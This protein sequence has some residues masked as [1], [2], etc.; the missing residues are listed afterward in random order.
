MT[1]SIIYTLP[2]CAV[3]T[4]P[5]NVRAQRD[6]PYSIQIHW[7]TSATDVNT[8]S[9]RVYYGTEGNNSVVITGSKVHSQLL[10]GLSSGETYTI[11]VMA[12][13]THLP[14][15]RVNAEKIHMSKLFYII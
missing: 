4:A 2:C 1:I 12:T 9:H 15:R 7:N 14:S 13:S 5:V 11:S 8:T 10:H 6:G 3:A